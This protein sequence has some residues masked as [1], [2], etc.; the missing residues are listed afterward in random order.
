MREIDKSKEDRAY[1]YIH[2][3]TL[4]MLL[5]IMAI[6]KGNDGRRLN[7]GGKFAIVEST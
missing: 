6:L 2:I 4:I 5:R 7:D 1:P 3:G